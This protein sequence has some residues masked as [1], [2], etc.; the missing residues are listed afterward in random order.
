MGSYGMK[1]PEAM[2]GGGDAIRGPDDQDLE[3]DL[4]GPELTGPRIQTPNQGD[5]GLSAGADLAM[6]YA[7]RESIADV[8]PDELGMD[9]EGA[10]QMHQQ[11]P[12]YAAGRGTRFG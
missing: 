2:K 7:H 3:K 12:K 6:G 1:D 10:G 4:N 8:E 9:T 11:M 5:S